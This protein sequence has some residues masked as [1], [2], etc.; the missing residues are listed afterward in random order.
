MEDISLWII[1]QGAPRGWQNN[2]AYCHCF[3]LSTGELD[4]KTWL[5][6]VSHTLCAGL[7]RVKLELSWLEVLAARGEKI[8][9]VLNIRR[10]YVL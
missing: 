4:S 5:L 1:G 3:G 9:T 8:V 2:I 6:K 10:H 7:L